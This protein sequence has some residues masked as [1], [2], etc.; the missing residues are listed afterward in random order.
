M[1]EGSVG[2]V[3]WSLRAGADGAGL[4]VVLDKELEFRSGIFAEYQNL[5]LVLFLVSS[6]WVVVI[7]LEYSETEIIGV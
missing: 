4:A 2:E 1:L 5:S 6:Y 3:A 7:H